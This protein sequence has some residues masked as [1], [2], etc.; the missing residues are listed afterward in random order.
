MSHASQSNKVL[1]VYNPNSGRGRVAAALGSIRAALGVEGIG[2][3]EHHLQSGIPSR[4]CVGHYRALIAAGGDGTVAALCG[5]ASET[6]VPLLHYAAGTENLFSREFM[7]PREAR[8]IARWVHAC[9]TKRIDLAQYRVNQSEERAVAIML[10]VGPDAGVI[11]RLHRVRRG[12][13]THLSYIPR[14]LEELASPTLPKVTIEV[15][16]KTV[17]QGAQG[18]TL[19]ANLRSYG[20]RFNPAPDADAADGEL[21]VVFMPARGSMRWLFNMTLSLL[22][23]SSMIPGRIK[24]RGKRVR[25]VTVGGAMQSDGEAVW[26]DVDSAEIEVQ[27]RPASLTILIDPDRR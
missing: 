3:D 8:Q 19:I 22:G 15:D 26:A 13:I 1:F 16:G 9:R 21:D 7:M 4:E 10:S 6:Q 2:L 5:V 11:H 25:I 27:I 12:A 14:V 17:A 20:G 18:M 23:A 24:V